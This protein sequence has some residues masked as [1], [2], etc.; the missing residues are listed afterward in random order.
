[1]SLH[2]FLFILPLLLRPLN[3]KKTAKMPS[4]LTNASCGYVGNSDIYGLGIHVG[5]YLQW[6]AS[7]LSKTFLEE[8]YIHDIFNE[9]SIFLVALFVAIILL[10][11]NFIEDAHNVDTLI[12][13]IYFSALH[14]SFSMT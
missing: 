3:P 8:K 14:K 2:F 1:M 5:I 7:I 4:E 6:V 9:S 10:I 12:C 11:T 13:Y